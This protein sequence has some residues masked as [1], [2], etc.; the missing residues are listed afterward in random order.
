MGYNTTLVVYLIFIEISIW[1]T[2]SK[3]VVASQTTAFTS[4]L[5]VTAVS[6]RHTISSSTNLSPVRRQYSRA[7]PCRSMAIRS[8]R[9]RRG[10]WEV[11]SPAQYVNMLGGS[12]DDTGGG[13]NGSCDGAGGDGQ[14]LVETDDGRGGLNVVVTGANRGLGFALAERMVGLGH[15]TVLACRNEQEASGN[16]F[17]QIVVHCENK[18]CQLCEYT[19]TGGN[20]PGR[21]E[22]RR[23]RAMFSLPYIYSH[24]CICM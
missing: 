14:G 5:R 23:C 9:R 22:T 12:V 4:L 17:I 2:C 20:S 24:I 16:V 21:C 18:S 3:F 11:M 10:Q 1:S 7:C 8:R 6:A 15:R 19:R 13:G